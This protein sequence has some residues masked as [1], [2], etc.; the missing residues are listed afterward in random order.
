MP[1]W[2]VSPPQQ[3]LAA[4]QLSPSPTQISVGRQVRSAQT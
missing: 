3:P 4:L 1:D 2:Q